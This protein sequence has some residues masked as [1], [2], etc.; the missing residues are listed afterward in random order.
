[1][2]LIFHWS[3]FFFI[4]ILKEPGKQYFQPIL[5]LKSVRILDS[6][7]AYCGEWKLLN[8]CY[9]D[10][11]ERKNLYWRIF[12]LNLRSLWSKY[13]GFWPMFRS[14]YYLKITWK[15]WWLF[16]EM[17]GAYNRK[18]SK[19]IVVLFQILI[20]FFNVSIL[21]IQF[22][23]L[24]TKSKMLLSML[25]SMVLSMLLLYDYHGFQSDSANYPLNFSAIQYSCGVFHLTEDPC[26]WS[27]GQF[28]ASFFEKNVCEK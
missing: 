15:W 2:I 18:L 23:R 24:F 19:T 16:E 10:Q 13:H 14:Y 7:V 20:V 11:F 21:V 4:P 5:I 26:C 22:L 27:A 25:L 12:E 28:I 8:L 1:M 9:F 3:R 6:F 17:N